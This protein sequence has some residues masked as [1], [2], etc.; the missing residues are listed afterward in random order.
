MTDLTLLQQ[1][2]D[3]SNRHDPYPLYARLREKPVH[4]DESGPYVIGGYHAVRALLHDPR[5]SSEARYRAVPDTTAPGQEEG[6]AGGVLPPNFLRLDPPEHDRLRAITNRPFGPP[7]SPHRIDGMHGELETIVTDL[8]D[9]LDGDEIDLVDRFSYPFPVTVICRLLG[10]PRE[11]E[12][13][14]HG[15]ADTLVATLDPQP[16]QDLTERN[17][18]AQQARVELGLYLNALIEERRKAPGDDML[19]QLATGQGP[20]GR[21]SG[22]EVLSTAALLLIAGHETTVNLITNGMLTLLRHP[23]ALERLRADAR[24]AVPLV[25]ELLR[26]EP[27]VQMLPSRTPITDIEVAG[28]TIPKGASL[29]LMLAAGNRDPERFADPD[30]FDPDRP[31]NQHLGL[32]SGIHSCFGAPLARLEAQL[33]L[34]GLARR[35]ERPRLVEDPPPYRTNAVLRGPRHLRIAIDGVR[36]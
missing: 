32:G 13:R 28:V 31:D 6:D 24:V 33:A 16:G 15:W 10:I 26:Y 14:F 9:A 12:S 20:E 4:H 35:L 18:I 17:R 11:D 29:W 30:R 21:L 25:E 36:R 27:P 1:I 34:A 3:Y 7:H 23:E 8:I 2:T 22:M 5:I 19:S